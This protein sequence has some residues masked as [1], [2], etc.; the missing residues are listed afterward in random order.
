[1]APSDRRLVSIL[2]PR[3]LAAG[4][5]AGLPGYAGIPGSAPIPSVTYAA[6]LTTILLFAVAF[7]LARRGQSNA[8]TDDMALDPLGSSPATDS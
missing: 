8:A 6:V 1:M 5:L 7:P 3:G 2:L 4:V